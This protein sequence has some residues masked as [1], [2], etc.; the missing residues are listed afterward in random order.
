MHAT[1][2][3]AQRSSKQC[4]HDMQH[5]MSQISV[6]KSSIETLS[7]T[8]MEEFFKI[9]QEL[10]TPQET[11]RHDICQTLKAFSQEAKQSLKV[12]SSVL[13]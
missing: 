2:K 6:L 5:V 11:L 7:T 12:N 9:R 8:V 1:S 10:K 3:E 4:C 13:E